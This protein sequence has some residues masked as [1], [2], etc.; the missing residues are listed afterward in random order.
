LNSS[1]KK[2]GGGELVLYVKD[3]EREGVNGTSEN[4]LHYKKVIC[5]NY[6]RVA[7]LLEGSSY[8]L[9]LSVTLGI[10]SRDHV[11]PF[12]AAHGVLFIVYLILSLHESH[13]RSWS[14]IVWLLILL[15]SI[16]PFAFIAVELFARKEVGKLRPDDLTL[17]K[18]K[19]GV[20]T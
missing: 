12:G 11:F 13:K 14:V 3:A 18:T 16:V 17:N 19:G 6:F 10:I 15:A 7:S 20:S 2:E 8:L 1:W 5:L 4:Q 9:I